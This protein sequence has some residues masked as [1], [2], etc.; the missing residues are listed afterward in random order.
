VALPGYSIFR[1]DRDGAKGGGAA[2][3]IKDSLRAYRLPDMDAG[4]QESVWC[5]IDLCDSVLI[6]GECYRSPSSAIDNNNKLLLAIENAVR[7][8]RN[9]IMFYLWGIL[10][11]QL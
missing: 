3:Y 5:R 6:V 4:F 11:I 9:G 8:T 10:I 7:Y 1:Q 2:S